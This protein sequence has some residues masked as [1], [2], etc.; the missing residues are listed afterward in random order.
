MSLR[1]KPPSSVHTPFMDQ[2]LLQAVR[3]VV[4]LTANRPCLM[5]LR[6]KPLNGFA[7]EKS[8]RA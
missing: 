1:S 6:S 7:G 4:G 3:R 5:S 8:F 2:L